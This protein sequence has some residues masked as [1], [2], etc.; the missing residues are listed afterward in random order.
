VPEYFFSMSDTNETVPF[1][2]TALPDMAPICAPP[3]S[4]SNS[5]DVLPVSAGPSLSTLNTALPSNTSPEEVTA[6]GLLKISPVPKIRR[7]KMQLFCSY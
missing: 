2:E 4:G 7:T 1:M 5:Q 6:S 3:T